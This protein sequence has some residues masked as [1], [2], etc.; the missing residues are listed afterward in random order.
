M[1]P[2]KHSNIDASADGENSV[3]AAVA[4]KRIAVLGYQLAVVHATARGTATFRSLTTNTDHATFMSGTDDL[5]GPQ[6]YSYFGDLQAP[7]FE[8]EVGEALGLNNGSGVDCTGH[9]TYCLK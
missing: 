4:G 9:L 7:V 2:V 8:C 6:V 3:V 5:D 1:Y